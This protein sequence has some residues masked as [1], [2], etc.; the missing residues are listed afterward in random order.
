MATASS[1]VFDLPEL[2]ELI[3]L[4][5]DEKDHSLLMTD[6]FNLGQIKALFTLQRVN[7]KFKAVL[8]GSRV[9][10]GRMCLRS[11]SEAEYLALRTNR[12]TKGMPPI[13]YAANHLS[14]RLIVE[15]LRN[16]EG[17]CTIWLFR[18]SGLRTELGIEGRTRLHCEMHA[19][20]RK[21]RLLPYPCTVSIIVRFWYSTFSKT[22]ELSREQATLGDLCD[23]LLGEPHTTNY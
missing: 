16:D 8:D 12:S 7:S 14:G 19:S 6:E 18:F 5:V 1:K 21:I 20:W 9:L 22:F 2:L 10:Q 13:E 17:P 4:L 11:F 15:Y 23:L 3:L